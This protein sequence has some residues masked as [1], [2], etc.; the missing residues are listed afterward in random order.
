MSMGTL[1]GGVINLIIWCV[2]EYL[3]STHIPEFELNEQP[4]S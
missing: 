4:G 2:C 3:P 1:F